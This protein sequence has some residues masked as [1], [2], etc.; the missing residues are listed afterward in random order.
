MGYL[1]CLGL[2]SPDAN[3][4]LTSGMSSVQE[5]PL[6][7]TY[8]CMQR[9][10]DAPHCPANAPAKSYIILQSPSCRY[11]ESVPTRWA[12]L[13]S[14]GI[15]SR[16]HTAGGWGRGGEETSSAP[17]FSLRAHEAVNGREVGKLSSSQDWGQRNSHCS[18]LPKL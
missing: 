9:A 17:R 7:V 15:L 12:C 1:V 6:R 3:S 18:S 8:S 4:A 2:S 13:D 11:R 14:D 5:L 10:A 16:K